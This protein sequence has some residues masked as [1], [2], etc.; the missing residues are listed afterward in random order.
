[1][2]QIIKTKFNF[3]QY[4]RGLIYVNMLE[5]KRNK[6]AYIIIAAGTLLGLFTS[7]VLAIS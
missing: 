5:L 7:I 1:M 2:A 6:E 4:V 3:K